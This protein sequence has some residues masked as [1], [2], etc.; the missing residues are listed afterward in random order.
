MKAKLINI[1]RHKVSKEVNFATY[2]GLIAQIRPL[3]MSKAIYLEP[4]PDNPKKGFVMAGVRSV[5]EVELIDATFS[6]EEEPILHI[7]PEKET[8]K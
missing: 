2:G 1:G 7:I 6:I 3:L 8:K 5:G 4:N